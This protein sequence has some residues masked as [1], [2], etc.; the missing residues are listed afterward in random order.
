M[1]QAC[2][3][4]SAACACGTRHGGGMLATQAYGS[5]NSMAK[6]RRG[7][8]VASSAA[9]HVISSGIMAIISSI[10]ISIS[11]SSIGMAANA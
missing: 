4:A 7:W 1:Q 5:I 2:S 8:Y 3:M 6:R 11:G 10:E 9:P